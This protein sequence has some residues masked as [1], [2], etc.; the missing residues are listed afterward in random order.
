MNVENKNSSSNS[1][2]QQAYLAIIIGVL[3]AVSVLLAAA[4]FFMIVRHRQRKSLGGSPLPDKSGW[5]TGAKLQTTSLLDHE[6]Q[7]QQPQQHQQQHQQHQ[8]LHSSPK[9]KMYSPSTYGG[10]VAAA[11]DAVA[12]AHLLNNGGLAQ[13]EMQIISSFLKK[14]LIWKK[15]LLRKKYVKG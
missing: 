12:T 5:T 14:K 15:K 11:A 4:I 1:E 9:S 6:H 7:H 8:L 13:L 2:S 3:V 10:S